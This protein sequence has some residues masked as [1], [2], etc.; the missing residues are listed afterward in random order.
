ME[1]LFLTLQRPPLNDVS[2]NDEAN[3]GEDESRALT[4]KDVDDIL[5]K[6]K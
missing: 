3:G 1:N 4:K 2:L 5:T 6:A